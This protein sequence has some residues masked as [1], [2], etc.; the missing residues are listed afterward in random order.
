[1]T[2]TK[3][4]LIAFMIN[5]L[6][7]FSALLVNLFFYKTLLSE[8]ISLA[9]ICPLYLSLLLE[10]K[11]KEEKFNEEDAVMKKKTK[12]CMGGRRN[13]WYILAEFAMCHDWTRKKK[14]RLSSEKFF[15]LHEQLSPANPRTPN[16]RCLSSEKK[17]ALTLYEYCKFQSS[18]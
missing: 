18:N 1:M 7:C 13:R 12:T 6:S 4:R 2:Y 10:K 14:I 15:S 17:L 8:S 16:C 11:I 3:R 5:Q 9:K